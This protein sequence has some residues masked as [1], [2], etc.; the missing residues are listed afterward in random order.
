MMYDFLKDMLDA[1]STDATEWGMTQR[2]GYEEALRAY[3][4][5]CDP[6]RP[7]ID[8][9]QAYDDHLRA[10]LGAMLGL[11]KDYTTEDFMQV[12]ADRAARYREEHPDECFDG[13]DDDFADGFGDFDDPSDFIGY[14]FGSI[15]EVPHGIRADIRRNERAVFYR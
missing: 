12:M 2:E 4:R 9:M 15:Y 8:D 6:K 10:A 3:M 13:F 1:D 11:K 5:M 7:P 14:G